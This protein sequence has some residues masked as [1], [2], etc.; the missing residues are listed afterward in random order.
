MSWLVIKNNS[1]IRQRNYYTETQ[2][3]VGKMVLCTIHIQDG[4]MHN[5]HTRW[6]YAQYTY[7]MVLC[8]IHTQDGTMHNTHTR[9]YYAQYT[10]KMVLCTVHIQDGTMHN[11]HTRWYYAQ[12]TYKM[13][14]TFRWGITTVTTCCKTITK[15]LT[16]PN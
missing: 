5:T 4:T 2:H 6:Y 11:T 7:K 10:Y 16:K 12:Y 3:P 15:I 14:S 13:Q 9:W 8:T 1:E